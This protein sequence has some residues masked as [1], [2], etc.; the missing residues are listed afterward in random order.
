MIEWAETSELPLR[1]LLNKADKLSKSK[2][3]Q[4]LGQFNKRHPGLKVT[5]A[6]CFSAL[7]A[8]GTNDLISWVRHALG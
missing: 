4:A 6:Q 2:Q 1:V 5:T 8:T 3:S 7:Q